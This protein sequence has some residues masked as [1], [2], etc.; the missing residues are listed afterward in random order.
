M[1]EEKNN[2][3]TCEDY[4]Y[5]QKLNMR[6]DVGMCDIHSG[7]WERKDYCNY[8]EKRVSNGQV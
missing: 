1:S 2:R 4:M 5:W 3:P 8:I 6:E 7:T